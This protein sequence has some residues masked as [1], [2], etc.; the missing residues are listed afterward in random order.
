MLNIDKT[1]E[2]DFLLGFKHK[3]KPKDWKDYN[4]GVIKTKLKEH[5]I[6]E[7]QNMYCPYCEKVI[8]D[9]DDCHIEHIM[10]RD[11]YPHKFQEY[12]N[13]IV[14]CNGK[15]SCGSFKKNNYCKD[16]INPVIDNPKEYLTYDI[17][18]GEVIPRFSE[19]EKY[20]KAEY[21]IKILNLNHNNLVQARATVLRVIES[22][23]GNGLEEYLNYYSIKQNIVSTIKATN[24]LINRLL[25]IRTS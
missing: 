17:S 4:D 5:V 2:P 24:N 20:E 9:T 6:L 13:L 14:S 25:Q 23:I 15:N 18:S 11:L 8:E 12:D 10:C 7:E 22:M 19:G 1:K 21:T 16:F 3:N